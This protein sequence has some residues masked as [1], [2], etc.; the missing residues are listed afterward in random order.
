VPIARLSLPLLLAALFAFSGCDDDDACR[1]GEP[2]VCADTNDCY[3]YC[4]EDGCAQDCHSLVNCGGVCQN[5]CTFD[6]YDL[7]NCTTS[8]GNNCDADC[9]N[10]VSCEAIQ[11]AN[12]SYRC[13]DADRCGAEVGNG[14]TVVCSRL[15]VC[16]VRCTGSCAVECDDVGRPCEL[17]CGANTTQARMCANGT[18]CSC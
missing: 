12:S 15:G 14:S 5:D 9:H 10:V 2:C 16:V 8:C 7:N 17:Y 6:C 4:E 3:L 11:G 13:A 18:T 1:P